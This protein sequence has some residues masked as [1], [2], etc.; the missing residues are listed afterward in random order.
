MD[1]RECAVFTVL[2]VVAGAMLTS[3]T[4]PQKLDIC[5][6]TYELAPACGVDGKTY[7]NSC[8]MRCSGV[9]M[10]HLGSCDM[11]TLEMRDE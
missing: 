9:Q 2:L 5:A 1:S 7:S 10:A 11:M 8:T 4:S 6:C 3:A